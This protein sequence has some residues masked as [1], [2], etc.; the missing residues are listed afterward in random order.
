MSRV[1]GK[2]T[3]AI[4]TAKDTGTISARLLVQEVAGIFYLA[5]D[6]SKSMTG[7]EPAIGGGTTGL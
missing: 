6:E 1:S 2:A 4:G 3:I 5:S 7:T